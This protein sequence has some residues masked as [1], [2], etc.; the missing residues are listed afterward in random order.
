MRSLEC[1]NAL[2]P[3]FVLKVKDEAFVSWDAFCDI[4]RPVDVG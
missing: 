3:D 2:A 4:R 1:R